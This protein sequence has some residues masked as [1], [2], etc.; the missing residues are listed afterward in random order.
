MNGTDT[1]WNSESLVLMTVMK[2]PA[3]KKDFD[4]WSLMVLKPAKRPCLWGYSLCFHAR[5]THP[6]ILFYSFFVFV[7]LFVCLSLSVSVSL[8]LC[9]SVCLYYYLYSYFCFL[10]YLSF[11]LSSFSISRFKN[12]HHHHHNNNKNSL[13]T[14]PLPPT[15]FCFC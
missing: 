11:C 1:T 14:V 15:P 6:P 8:Y 9:L 10:K 12:K 2:T 5:A 3:S 13:S 7:C 4:A